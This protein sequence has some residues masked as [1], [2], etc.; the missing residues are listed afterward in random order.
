[1]EV[2]SGGLQLEAGVF[3]PK[4]DMSIKPKLAETALLV[5]GVTAF[6]PEMEQRIKIGRNSTPGER[7]HTKDMQ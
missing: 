5:C 6:Q 7:Q 4:R 1:M 2:G 3:T